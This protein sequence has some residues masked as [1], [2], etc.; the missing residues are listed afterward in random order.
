MFSGTFIWDVPRPQVGRA[1]YL[2]G[3]WELGTI[4]TATS[5]SPFTMTVGGG[6]DPLGTGF[7]GDFSMDYASFVPGCNPIR[8]GVNYINT[9]CL[10]LPFAPTAFRL[11]L[12]GERSCCQDWVLQDGTHAP[13]GNGSSA[14][15]WSATLAATVSTGPELKTVDFSVFKN[16]Q[17]MERLKLQFRAEFFNIL[18]HPNLLRRTS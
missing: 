3:G 7:N 11:R 10:T 15:T 9:N 16:I 17:L 2:S 14:Q 1:S 8:G 12:P 4:I 13:V 18:N 5:G 6:D